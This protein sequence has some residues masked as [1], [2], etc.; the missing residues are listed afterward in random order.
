MRLQDYPRPPQ[1]N[2][3]GMHWSGGNAGAVGGGEL[4]R[5]WIPE[6]ATHGR[7]MGQ[8]PASMAAWS[9]PKCC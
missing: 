8:T 9:S 5:Q 2:G 6:T 4:R 3:I 1:D 7:E